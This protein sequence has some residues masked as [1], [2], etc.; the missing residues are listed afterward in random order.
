MAGALASRLQPAA[1]VAVLSPRV[2]DCAQSPAQFLVQI[3]WVPALRIN[4]FYQFQVL[5]K[6]F[7]SRADLLEPFLRII[8]FALKHN[9]RACQLVGHFGTAAVQFLLTTAQFFELALLLFDLFLLALEL[10]Q[11]LLRFLHLRLQML[12]R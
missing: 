3:S 9:E 4:R 1:P 12:G 7:P 10:E 11:L 8:R 2:I 6:T 5:T